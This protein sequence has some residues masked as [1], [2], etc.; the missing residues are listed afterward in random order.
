MLSINGKNVLLI[1]IKMIEMLWLSIKI[2]VKE[3]KFN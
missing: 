2:V 1:I 3:D